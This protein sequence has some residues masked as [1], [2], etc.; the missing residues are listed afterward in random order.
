MGVVAAP[1]HGAGADEVSGHDSQRVVLES[2]PEIP[3]PILTWQHWQAEDLLAAA[4]HLGPIQTLEYDYYPAGLEPGH[5]EPQA[6]APLAHVRLMVEAG[7]VWV[8]TPDDIGQSIG[9][10]RDGLDGF[11][12]ASL[13]V[14]FNRITYEEAQASA[15][16]FAREVIPNFL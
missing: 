10:Y 16:L 4:P 7:T 15:S 5:Y 1:H 9:A 14:N 3:L 12:I 13:Q 11:G 8:G 2:H 6:W